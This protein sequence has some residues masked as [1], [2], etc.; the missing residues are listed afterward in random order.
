MN[1]I[2]KIFYVLVFL[3]LV[4]V[5]FAQRV[6]Q[7]INDGWLFALYDGDASAKEFNASDWETV[8]IPHSWNAKDSDDEVKGFYRGKGWYRKL[9]NVE[10]LVDNQ[11]VFITFEAA[12]QE[13]DVYV[14]G[15]H[16]G[17]H[18]GGY[19]AFT[20]DISDQ[21]EVGTNVVAVLVDNH[22][23]L[24]IAPLSADFTFFGGIYRDVY[25]VYTPQALISPTHYSTSG[26]YL[27]TP[28]ISDAKA[29]V[30][31][32]TY[33]TNSSADKQK[34]V[35]QTKIVDAEGKVV[36]EANDKVKLDADSENVAF[37]TKLSLVNP[38]RW[39]VDAPYMYKVYTSL[40]DASGKELDCVI[41]PLGIREYSFDTN[42]GFTLNGRDLKLMGTNRH[43]D[44][45]GLGNALRDEMH[46]RDVKL[47][48]DMGSNFFRVSHYPQDP[49]VM[50]QCDQLGL[51]TS[52]E[53]PIIN[54]ITLTEAFK[55]NCI[56]QTIEMIYQDF[57]SPSVIIWAY[58]N[59]V[60][61]RPPYDKDDEPARIEYMD[62]LYD[63]ASAIEAK[64]REIDPARYTMLPCHSSYK[65]YQ[66]SRISEL[67]M[68]LGFNIY[69]GWYGGKFSGFE[70]LLEVLH[71]EFPN[72]G[73]FV[74]EYGADVD[75]RLHSFNPVRFDFSCEFGNLFHEHY[76]PEILKRDFI[77]GATVWNLNDFFSE[78]RSDAVPHVNN[79][80]IVGT[81]RERKDTYFLYQAYLKAE[82]I[83]HITNKSWTSRAGAS[84]DG[85][86]VSQDLKIYT[87]APEVE[88][89]L[90]G[91]SQGKLAVKDMMAIT[92]VDYVDGRNVVEAIVTKDG[93][94]YRD[95]SVI[96][97]EC[98]NVKNGFSQMSVMM[99]SD[100]YFEDRTAEFCWIPEQEYKE[101][102]WGYIGGDKVV[103][104]TRYGSLPASEV[105]ILGT[106]QDPVFQTQR[107]DLSAFK[108]DVPDGSY[109]IYLYFAELTSENKREA[110]AYNLGN[111]AIAEDYQ[112]RVFSIDIN[113]LKVADKFNIA[114][115]Y[116]S[117][118]AV[119]KKYIVTASGGEGLTISFDKVESLPVLNAIRILKQ[120]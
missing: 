24:D 48:K 104:K 113:G 53:I 11:K 97:F 56:D 4:N 120:Y 12:N 119:I 112:N 80:G 9:V 22:E 42:K 95:Q 61:L 5:S 118:R 69:N 79:K 8:S 66:Q 89:V 17:N 30:V 70:D 44:Y 41:N 45:L 75:P 76:I 65:V 72:Q 74:S 14:N 7:T 15:K 33:L 43:Q 2:T 86:T 16:V 85:K 47:I 116:G 110:L 117:E 39:D 34:L 87:N 21:V 31:A 108:A 92:T 98:I 106:D 20:F 84:K 114:E 51:L 94:E 49:V 46:V 71:K 35:L 88:V 32:K 28:E 36:A 82:P 81:N 109:A 77:H 55:Q 58:M 1:K 13:A 67:P 91:K 27:T 102:E 115:E 73:L 103:T 38:T 107:S 90:N 26:V 57:N 23:N 62:F 50:Q 6:K 96:E 105:E 101:G 78:G 99:G 100:R 93:V 25:L 37:E 40:L 60:M 19:S 68:L 64:I 83:V 10:S 111:D 18:K 59:E 3:S 63:I 54:R 52:V 29:S